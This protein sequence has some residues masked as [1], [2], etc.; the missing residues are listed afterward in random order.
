MLV[1]SHRS[2]VRCATL[3]VGYSKPDREKLI[4]NFSNRWADM[5]SKTHEYKMTTVIMV[6]EHEYNTDWPERFSALEAW[7]TEHDAALEAARSGP[8]A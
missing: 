3:R 8:K 5:Y 7:L 6:F 4:E 1:V 2:K